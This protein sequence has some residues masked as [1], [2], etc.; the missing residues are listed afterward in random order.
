MEHDLDEA[1]VAGRRLVDARCRSAPTAGGRG[2]PRRC[3]RCTCRVACGPPRGLRAS[4]WRRRRRRAGTRRSGRPAAGHGLHHLALPTARTRRASGEVA[5]RRVGSDGRGWGWG[6]GRA[7]SSSWPI[8][9]HSCAD[10]R[11]VALAQRAVLGPQPGEAHPAGGPA[12]AGH[13]RAGGDLE[14]SPSLTVTTTT[15][16]VAGPAA[17]TPAP[18]RS[19]MPATPPGAGPGRRCRRRRCAA[20]ARRWPRARPRRPRVP[21]RRPPGD[22]RRSRAISVAPSRSDATSSA[23]EALGHAAARD[24]PRAA[25]PAG[26]SRPTSARPGRRRT[27]RPGPRPGCARRPAAPRRR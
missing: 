22:R 23:R 13:V 27:A 20:P 21:G 16:A 11:H 10:R 17:T 18:G 24:E 8:T 2:R 14:P 3:R 7:G 15:V 12:L 1:G 5:S 9:H 19:F 4:G 26:A 25:R 6:S